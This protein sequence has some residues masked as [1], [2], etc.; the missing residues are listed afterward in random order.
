MDFIH[1]ALALKHFA[2]NR[3]AIAG[4]YAETIADLNQL[5]RHFLILAASLQAARRFRRQF[6]QGADRAAGLLAGA[7]FQHLAQQYENGDHRGGFEVNGDRAAHPA[8]SGREHSRRKGRKEAVEVSGT[9]P[10]GDQAEHVQ[11]AVHD[12]RPGAFEEWPPRPQDDRRGQSELNPGGDARRD[13]IMQAKS[14]DV[15][16]HFQDEDRQRQNQPDPEPPGHVREFAV[17]ADLRRRFDRL[18]RHSADRAIARPHLADLRV[19]RAGVDDARLDRGWRGRR[20]R[21][22]G[23]MVIHGRRSTGQPKASAPSRFWFRF[24]LQFRGLGIGFCF[25]LRLG[26][27]F[28]RLRGRDGRLSLGDH[29]GDCHGYSLVFSYAAG[30]VSCG[31]LVIMLVSLS[32]A[33]LYSPRRAAR[34]QLAR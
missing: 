28:K 22:T 8:E 31:I 33:A 26:F 25:R 2:I 4:P 9:R 15:A 14:G 27:G 16:A 21:V 1:G 11:A 10:E 12:R 29:L 30:L 7:Q 6:E 24:R 5:K 13:E 19:H 23:A 17:L 34:L 32:S 3:H 18:Q 20:C